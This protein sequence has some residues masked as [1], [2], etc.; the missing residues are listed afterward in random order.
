MSPSTDSIQTTVG[1]T[2][3]RFGSAKKY[4]AGATV[5]LILGAGGYVA[6]QYRTDTA[7]LYQSAPVERKTLTMSVSATGNLEPVNTVDVGIEV[8]GTI[9]EVTVDYNDRVRAGEVLARLDTTKLASSVASSKAAAARYGANVA[10]ARAGLAYASNE[11]ERVSK[12][13]EA[14]GGNYP[15]KKEMDDA[16]TA[17]DKARSQLE[18]AKAQSAQASA[19][20]AFNE[21]NLRKAVVVSPIEGIVLERK[22]E[23]GQTV[24]ASMQTPVLFKLAENLTKMRVLLSVDEADIGEVREHQ[25]VE[26]GV[27][28][29]PERKFR[30]VITQLR[31]NPQTLNGVV[32]YD[33]VVDVDNTG[34]LLRPGMTVSA[35]IITGVVS[36][37]LTIPNAALRF[38]PP[39]NPEENKKKAKNNDDSRQR[40]VW[41]L[42]EN[43][44]VKIAIRTAQ[45]DGSFTVVDKS[46]LKE[47]DTVLIGTKEAP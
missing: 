47:G 39:A 43:Q 5:L 3:S 45:S 19:E 23:R 15:S 33:A 44:P 27:D 8:S 16:R 20:L 46:T 24:V 7:P 28:A 35:Q 11:W 22:V 4:L 1:V 41:I 2:P 29:Y 14:T 34:R 6:Y 32:T 42:K 40:H 26:F 9:S 18:A 17:L 12:M 25:K 13:F 36:D 38:T 31:L 10:E 37:A 21:N 30:G